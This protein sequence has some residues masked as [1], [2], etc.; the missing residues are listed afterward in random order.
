MMRNPMNRDKLNMDLV[1]DM[2]KGGIIYGKFMGCILNFN[3]GY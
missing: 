3:T 2:D 1:D